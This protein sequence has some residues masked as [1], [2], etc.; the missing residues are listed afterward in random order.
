MFKLGIITDEMSQDL[1]EVLAFSKENGL[2]CFELRTAWDK[3]PFAMND[4]DFDEV[5]RLSKKYDIPLVCISSPMFKCDI[6]DT[7]TKEAH[8]QGLERLAK[9]SSELGFKYIRC[10]NFLYS[11]N[12]SYEDIAKEFEKPFEICKKYDVTLVLEPE[13]SAN[14]STCRK[15]ADFVKYVN[16]PYFKGLYEP[17]NMIYT[18]GGDI[19]Y[20]DGYEAMK[21]VLCHIHIKDAVLKDGEAVGVAIGK[22]LV[23]YKGIFSKLIS[24]GYNGCVM[25]EPHYKIGGTISKEQ[26]HNPGGSAFSE[27]G[28]ASCLECIECVNEILK[29]IK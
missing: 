6:S 29:E 2:N 5:G 1:E 10:F 20:P 18:P 12:L 7:Q 19:P 23:D 15:T 14:S 25:L 3:G 13:P 27:N 9:K 24:T 26:M 28:F 22:G 4:E 11:E 16:N 17:G 21:D 8:I